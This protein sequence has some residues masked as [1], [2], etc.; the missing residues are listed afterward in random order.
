MPF[1]A[2][3]TIVHPFHGPL[4]VVRITDRT[5]RGVTQSYLDL[6]ALGH[7]LDMSVPVGRA[8]D[9]G[10]RL[11]ASRDRVQEL[12]AVLGGPTD[13]QVLGWSRRLKSYQERVNSG[14]VDQLCFVIRE[15][16]RRKP[17][18][19]ASS[20]SQL[21]RSARSTLVIEFS[22]ALGVTA[23]QAGRLIDS[24]AEGTPNSATLHLEALPA[25]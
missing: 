23:E 25:A 7:P 22:I 5:V 4:R 11:V 14:D 19:P 20:E 16:T 24:A 3:Q 10:L 18:S 13:D 9:V 21:L 17:K 1:I 6:Q 15:I 8:E 12:L 2:G